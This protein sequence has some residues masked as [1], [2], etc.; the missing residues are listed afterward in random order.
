LRLNGN[1]GWNRNSPGAPFAGFPGCLFEE[2]WLSRSEHEPGSLRCKL[3][4][5]LTT[6]T[7][8]AARD[9]DYILAEDIAMH[10]A[11]K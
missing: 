11:R 6:N 1:V 8:G 5:Q 2:G 9:D 10:C 4:R 7:G 3:I